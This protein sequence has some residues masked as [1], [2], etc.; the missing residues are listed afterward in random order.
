MNPEFDINKSGPDLL[1]LPA[2]EDSERIRS[3]EVY[4]DRKE[5]STDERGRERKK[6]IV[7]PFHIEG[8]RIELTIEDLK[9][10]NLNSR[11]L[12]NEGFQ[13]IDFRH[14]LTKYF[15]SQTYLFADLI[16]NN[17]KCRLTM[18]KFF[19]V[20]ALIDNIQNEFLNPSKINFSLIFARNE[21]WIGQ[22]I[23]CVIY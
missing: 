10:P 11:F 13:D 7:F 19:P 3:D 20:D 18:M 14:S 15:K 4:E 21:S 23:S 16:Q 17:D 1:P 5:M 8:Q 12:D 9:D 22:S 2:D 6:E